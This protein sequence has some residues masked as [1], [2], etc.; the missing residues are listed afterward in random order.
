MKH[1]PIQCKKKRKQLTFD[2][3]TI[4]KTESLIHKALLQNKQNPVSF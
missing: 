2:Q 4:L 3:K 1:V